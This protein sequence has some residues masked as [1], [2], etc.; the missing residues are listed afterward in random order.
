MQIGAVHQFSMGILASPSPD[1]MIVKLEISASSPQNTIGVCLMQYAK[2]IAT[3]GALVLGLFGASGEAAARH[4]LG[5]VAQCGPDRAYLCPIKG[6][7]DLAPFAY[8]LAIYPG[9]IK[10]QRVQTP[11]GWKRQRVLVCG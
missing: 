4:R 11:T 10:T 6:Y 7:F 9:C 2:N 1:T 3:I 8:N 5:P